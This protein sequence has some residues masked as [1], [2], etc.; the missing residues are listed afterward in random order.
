M[1]Y[2]RKN[3]KFRSLERGKVFVNESIRKVKSGS[4]LHGHRGCVWSCVYKI[5]AK[6]GFFQRSSKVVRVLLQVM[7]GDWS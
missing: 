3:N 5:V 4:S 1:V 2:E 6:Q 7:S